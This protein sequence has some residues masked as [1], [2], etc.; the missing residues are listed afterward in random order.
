M[1]TAALQMAQEAVLGDAGAVK[2]RGYWEQVWIRLRR[3]RFALGGGVAIALLLFAAFAGA[4][5]AA[6]LLGHGPND[7]FYTAMNSR[8]APLGP[9]ST[10]ADPAH[11]GHHTLFILGA[12]STLGR[13]EFLRVLYGARV[14]FEVG[15]LATLGSVSLGTVMGCLAGYY[16][17]WV[18][19]LVSRVTEITMA[20]PA[21][22]FIIAL[23]STVGDS[24]DTIT[25]GVFDNG[26]VL[27]FVVFSAF[28]WFFPA[29]IVRAVVLSVREK[30]FVDA[31]RMTGASD[32]RIMRSHIL[33]HLTA[34]LVVLSTL[35]V[36]SFILGEAGLSFLGVGIKL[37]AASWGNLLQQAAG[38]YT[39]QPWLMLWPGLAVLITTLSFNLL[40]DG[41]RDAFDPRS[42]R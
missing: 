25:F 42:T 37:P 35:F 33:P 24:L 36:A 5:I 29:R 4:P 18:D 38:F 22:L 1:A 7:L 28:G 9:W 27:L 3:D 8:G 19:T 39:V 16:R 21:L 31:A 32:V 40:G 13:D 11:P 34:P 14:S 30:E 10:V 2:A 41:L 26:V 12:D 17:G 20:F 15:I 23:S 6:A